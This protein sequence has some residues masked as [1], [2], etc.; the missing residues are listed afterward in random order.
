MGKSLV[1]DLLS[2]DSIHS[3]FDLLI[4]FIASGVACVFKP[5]DARFI[6]LGWFVIFLLWAYWWWFPIG[7][8]DMPVVIPLLNSYSGMASLCYTVLFFEIIMCSSFAGSPRWSFRTYSY[9]KSCA[10]TMN[11]SLTNVLLGSFG[12]GCSRVGRWLVHNHS[13]RNL[14]SRKQRCYSMQLSSVFDRSGFNG[15]A[16][17][18]SPARDSELWSMLKAK[19]DSSLQ[20]HAGG[21]ANAAGT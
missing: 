12:T 2:R 6:W 16:C 20:I 3:Y 18:A 11:R 19:I 9:P 14:E 8:A 4:A 10:R 15:M 5:E 13:Q 7:G 1:A 21:R 17:G